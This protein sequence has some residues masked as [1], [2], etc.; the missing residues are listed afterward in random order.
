MATRLITLPLPNFVKSNQLKFTMA[1]FA[2]G[3]IPLNEENLLAKHR[4]EKKDLQGKT[5]FTLHL[6]E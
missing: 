2:A 6:K 3:E 1:D 4:K 5:L